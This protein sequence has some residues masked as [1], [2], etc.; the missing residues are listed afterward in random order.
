MTTKDPA[1]TPE[2]PASTP[3][4]AQ[5]PPEVVRLRVDVPGAD[6]RVVRHIAVETETS[7]NELVC[8]GVRLLKRYY[9]A[10]G[11]PASAVC[12]HLERDPR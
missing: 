11:I 2:T 9:A 7:V 10:Q 1:A 8:E 6:Y 3:P 4:P 5:P 12:G